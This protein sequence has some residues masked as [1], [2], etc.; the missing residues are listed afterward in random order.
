MN[1]NFEELS[2]DPP[3]VVSNKIRNIVS[4]WAV[5]ERYLSLLQGHPE[6]NKGEYKKEFDKT[7]TLGNE[8][9]RLSTNLNNNI[10][11]N[12]SANSDHSS[13]VSTLLSKLE[14]FVTQYQKLVRLTDNYSSIYRVED[15]FIKRIAE[16]GESIFRDTQKRFDE[17]TANVREDFQSGLDELKDFKSTLKQVED[18]GVNIESELKAARKKESWFMNSFIVTLVCIPLAVLAEHYWLTSIDG[19]NS[20]ILKGSIITS[21]LFISLFHFS[22][23]RTYM[24]IRLRYTHLDGFLRGGSSFVSQLVHSSDPELKLETNKKLADMFMSLD[25]VLKMVQKNKHP[26]ELTLET[27]ETVFDKIS[28]FREKK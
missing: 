18:F 25:D 1:I 27:A 24:M 7:R 8:I 9:S 10:V 22:Q 14:V 23:Y 3:R 28:K 2:N 13:E 4:E 12:K 11:Q 16:L 17:L 26:T 21:L 19:I 5:E 6:A 20:Y 15:L